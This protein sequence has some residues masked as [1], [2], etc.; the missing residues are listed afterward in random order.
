M[1]ILILKNVMPSFI[2]SD[3]RILIV[4]LKMVNIYKLL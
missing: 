4:S 1:R 2:F 3:K